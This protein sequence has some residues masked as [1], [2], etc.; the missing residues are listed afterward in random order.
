MQE[1]VE[2]R[3]EGREAEA[4][5]LSP[6]TLSPASYLGLIDSKPQTSFRVA[7]PCRE[8]RETPNA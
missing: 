6:S 8:T 1:S 7:R 3:E 5:H 4:A 2:L